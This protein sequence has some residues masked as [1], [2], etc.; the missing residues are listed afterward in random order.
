MAASGDWNAPT[1]E[2]AGRVVMR[3]SNL[4]RQPGAPSQRQPLRIDRTAP[5]TTTDHDVNVVAATKKALERLV[6]QN[7]YQPKDDFVIT[8]RR[9]ESTA[10]SLTMSPTKG[11]SSPSRQDRRMTSAPYVRRSPSKEERDLRRRVPGGDG[12]VA[13]ARHESLQEQIHP[14]PIRVCPPQGRPS[15]LVVREPSAST[16][17]SHGRGVESSSLHTLSARSPAAAAKVLSPPRSPAIA[18]GV[19]NGVVTGL[20]PRSR[21]EGSNVSPAA[22]PA[23][24]GSDVAPRASYDSSPPAAVAVSAARA[25]AATHAP[26]STQHPLS[27]NLSPSMSTI[28]IAAATPNSSTLL[29][30]A[31]VTV[32]TAALP[33]M[34]ANGAGT[35][36]RAPAARNTPDLPKHA[37]APLQPKDSATSNGARESTRGEK[38]GSDRGGATTLGVDDGAG[39]AELYWRCAYLLSGIVLGGTAVGWVVLLR[40]APAV[41]LGGARSHLTAPGPPPTAPQP[42]FGRQHTGATPSSRVAA[43]GGAAVPSQPQVAPP[44]LSPLS[45][46]W[47]PSPPPPPPPPW[48]PPSPPP[49][50]PPSVPAPRPPNLWYAESMSAWLWEATVGLIQ[51]QISV[52]TAALLLAVAAL[53]ACGM[54]RTQ[55]AAETR[56]TAHARGDETDSQRKLDV[57]EDDLEL[58]EPVYLALRSWR[59]ARAPAP[60]PTDAADSAIAQQLLD[61][62]RA[63]QEQW[64]E[65]MEE[66]EPIY[67]ALRSWSPGTQQALR[68]W[69]PTQSP[70]LQPEQSPPSGSDG[71][72]LRGDAFERESIDK[73]PDDGEEAPAYLALHGWRGHTCATPAE[74]T[75]LPLT[76]E[77]E[78]PSDCDASPTRPAS[79]IANWAPDDPGASPLVSD[80]DAR[81]PMPAPL[82]PPSIQSPVRMARVIRV[83]RAVP[84]PER[85]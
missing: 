59:G 18:N 70:R 85:M 62:A 47:P 77:H 69:Q 43:L 23:P 8:P 27:L 82:P 28:T 54:V 61:D 25:P 71:Q 46:P 26:S 84:S 20:A 41:P 12:Y 63:E 34:D 15:P 56:R 55:P 78:E 33:A 60:A 10:A 58:D 72:P 36:C 9:V 5:G 48:L 53:L 83:L 6:E 7:R 66:E 38:A 35:S 42:S 40:S 3:R 44:R 75:Y 81:L 11:P 52:N 49:P 73:S 31:S 79:A 29:S 45:P 50:S 68:S 21:P 67:L 17:A 74:A 64:D 57:K 14:Q 51:S 4:H 16:A 30:A 39:S 80:G 1:K 22:S 65:R 2:R 32:S 37:L 76:D 24:V 13:L 19:A